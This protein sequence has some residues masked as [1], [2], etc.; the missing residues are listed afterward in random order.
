MGDTKT[1]RR[2][3]FEYYLF[4]TS[5]SGEINKE[6]EKRLK[7]GWEISEK[8][9]KMSNGSNNITYAILFEKEKKRKDKYIF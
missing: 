3:T 6:I 8:Q 2:K 4:S 9:F 5:N 1:T 7:K